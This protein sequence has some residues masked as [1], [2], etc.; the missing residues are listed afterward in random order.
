M[1]FLSPEEMLEVMP[2]E[3]QTFRSPIPTRPF[4]SDEFLPAP[5]NEKQREFESRI[6]QYGD[7]LAAHQGISRRR[8]FRTAAGMAAAFVAM[9]DTYG[10][11]FGVS[12]AEAA[13]PEMATE[14][15]KSLSGQFIMD[16]HTH[17]LRD[18]TR[19]KG[20]IAQRAAV[21]RAGWNPALAGKEQTIEDLK[22]ANYFK[23]VF[24]DSDTKVAMIS[25]APSDIPIDWFL[26]NEMKVEARAKINKESGSRRAMSHAIFTPGQPGWLEQVDHAIRD[27]RPDSFKGY[28]IG[29]NSNKDISKYPWR[30]DD[31]K[32][33][34]P[35]YEKVVKAGLNNICVHK[36]LFPPSVEKQYPHLLAYSD[37]RDVGRAARDWP[38]LN[39]IVYHSAYRYAAGGRA[40]DGLAQFERT[41]R[42]DWV[43][44]LADIPSKFGVNNVYGDLGQIFAQTTMA[45][46]RLAAA[47][48]GILTRGLGHER[49]VWGTDAVWTGSPQWQI[50][51]LRRLEIPEDLQKKHGF[52]PLGAADGPV[53]SAIFA[54]N[55]AR[56][57][58]YPEPRRAEL[59]T[60]RFAQMKRIY[61]ANGGERSNQVYGFVR[62]PAPALP[63]TT[64]AA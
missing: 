30:L 53:K 32:L 34:Y 51:S 43:S 11:V 36:G 10:P 27:L 12:R 26:T 61:E 40:E 2:A 45:E 22:F 14:R 31:E 41:G 8:F 15:A 60:D 37:V 23:E 58:K 5:Q 35:F 46:P 28:T 13:T 20:F 56:I 55:N 29:D 9:N 44:D 38:Q 63:G 3:E 1:G 24:L 62:K 17:F 25:G 54:G 18:D 57:Y 50:E 64:G 16:M 7:E 21:G 4:S 47:M 52:R 42:V 48:M 33:L 19:I 6:R 39:F 59:A 49:V